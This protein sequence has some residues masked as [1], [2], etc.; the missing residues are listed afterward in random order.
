M[1]NEIYQ[2][3]KGRILC[4][5]YPPGT[6]LNEKVLAEEFDVSRTPL[7]EVLSRLEWDQLVRILPRTGTM[8]AEIEFQQIMNTFHVRLE[9]EA[10]VGRLAADNISDNYMQQL[11]SLL[12]QCGEL[13]Q[14]KSR[15]KASLM[16]IDTR[17][18]AILSHCAN[19]PVLKNISESL[20]DI[21]VRLWCTI[22]DQGDWDEEVQLL[23]DEIEQTISALTKPEKNLGLLR[24]EILNGQIQRISQKFLGV[25]N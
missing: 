12:N 19:N 9:I 24:R 14:S 8:V 1:N 7:R 22:L 16:E 4:L 10:M 20:Y 5:E 11:H 25:S 17:L 18:R 13:F 2:V 23:Y 6:I 21:T 15:D 3:I